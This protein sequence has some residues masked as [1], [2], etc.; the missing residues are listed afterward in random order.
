MKYIAVYRQHKKRDSHKNAIWKKERNKERK[1]EI[2]KERKKERRKERK[3]KRKKERK[4]KALPRAGPLDAFGVF[5]RTEDSHLSVFAVEC[6]QTFETSLSIVK[7]RRSNVNGNKRIFFMLKLTPFPVFEVDLNKRMS[8]FVFKSKRRPI[9]IGS[10][11]LMDHM[12]ML[13]LKPRKTF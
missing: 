8:L 10:S 9:K 6:L 3:K 5:V 4:K 2:N 1:K 13:I 11:Y 12:K 7:S